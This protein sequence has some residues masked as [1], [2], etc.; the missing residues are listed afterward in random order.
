MSGTVAERL[1]NLLPPRMPAATKHR[2]VEGLWH[3]VGP[4]SKKTMRIGLDATVS[5]IVERAREHVEDVVVRYQIPDKLER[6]FAWLS[7]GD[8]RVKQELLNYFRNMEKE[9][10]VSAAQ[11]QMPVMLDHLRSDEAR[12]TTRLA[13][14][15]KVGKHELE[16]LL[17]RDAHG[18]RLEDPVPAWRHSG[19]ATGAGGG[20]GGLW[21]IAIPI[22]ALILWMIFR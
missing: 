18:V 13:Q 15:L 11:A 7:A 19:T 1:F 21:W 4:S 9:L 8:A 6:R 22:G 5:D 14:I 2:L 20:G 10:V 12:H 17:D 3:H 16:L